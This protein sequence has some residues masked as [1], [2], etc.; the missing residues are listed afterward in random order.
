MAE[1]TEHK[2]L[3][4]LIGIAILGGLLLLLAYASKQQKT[5]QVVQKQDIMQGWKPSPIP[6]VDTT[7]HRPNHVQVYDQQPTP[8]RTSTAQTNAAQIS[9][10]PIE[11]KTT[12]QT[13]A[14]QISTPP[15]EAKT[16][17]H[18]T[19]GVAA[20]PNTVLEQRLLDL[21]RQI[22]QLVKYS[23]SEE[24]TYIFNDEGDMIGR[25]TTRNAEIKK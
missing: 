23:N 2:G 20:S 10:P 11:P 5:L 6:K 7:P 19:H 22:Q 9:T 1:D 12:A 8:V 4:T 21:E 17:P 3:D 25:K 15:I 16:T 13:N 18:A 24:T 14:V